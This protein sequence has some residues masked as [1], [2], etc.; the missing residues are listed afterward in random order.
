MCYSF[1]SCWSQVVLPL[2]IFHN[3]VHFG[4][5]STTLQLQQNVCV[6]VCGGGGGGGGWGTE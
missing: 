3:A 1:K 5:P 4:V 6:C 2:P